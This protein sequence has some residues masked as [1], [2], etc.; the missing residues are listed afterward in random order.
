MVGSD[1]QCAC[2]LNVRHR[3]THRRGQQHERKEGKTQEVDTRP[4]LAPPQRYERQKGGDQ[5]RRKEK[6]LT[7]MNEL[8]PYLANAR[9]LYGPTDSR[10]ANGCYTPGEE[11][12]MGIQARTKTTGSRF[13]EIG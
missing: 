4:T 12:G 13:P 7:E 10:L 2:E 8:A 5:D 9:E 6:V 11:G 1:R 3:S